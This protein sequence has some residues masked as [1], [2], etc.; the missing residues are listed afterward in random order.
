MSCLIIP[1]VHEH[2]GKLMWI[3]EKYRD[4]VD[5]IVLLGDFY[6]AWG[7]YDG[8]RTANT[9]AAHADLIE[10][11]KVTCLM[12]NHDVQY[13]FPDIE[14]LQC[15][16]FNPRRIP[17]IN[18]FMQEDHWER[19]RFFTM[20]KG[21]LISHAG[22]QERQNLVEQEEHCRANLFRHRVTHPW[23]RAGRA[24]GG[25]Q[26]VGGITWLDFDTEFEPVEGYRQIVGHTEGDG[27]RRKGENYCIDTRDNMVYVGIIDDD[28][29]F[30][31]EATRRG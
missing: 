29:S 15:S 8:A 27:V 3:V 13:A 24:R 11:P 9:A 17:V 26:S 30:H 19:V 20:E 25:T 23:V 22:I 4:H 16:G 1:D 21:W 7:P 10:D 6:D 28:G 2:D 31:T 18:R 12:G 5:R 14:S